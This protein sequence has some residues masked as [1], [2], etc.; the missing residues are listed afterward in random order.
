MVPC[1]S[2]TTTGLPGEGTVDAVSERA[3]VSV[4]VSIIADIVRRNQKA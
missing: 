1:T 4:S 3:A 2:V